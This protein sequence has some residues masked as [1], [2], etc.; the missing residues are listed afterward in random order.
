MI[1]RMSSTN[2]LPLHPLDLLLLRAVY[3]F[4]C[5]EVT[6]QFCNIWT[7]RTMSDEQTNSNQ[8]SLIHED[9][10]MASVSVFKNPEFLAIQGLSCSGKVS[11]TYRV[12]WP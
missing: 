3:F 12:I 5:K 1:R 6:D 8:C 7:E 9:W 11:N 10:L 4:P 2:G